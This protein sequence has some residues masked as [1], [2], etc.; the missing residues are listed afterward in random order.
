MPNL[1]IR[2]PVIE[3]PPLPTLLAPPTVPIPTPKT[4]LTGMVLVPAGAFLMGCAPNDTRCDD[5]EK[6][7]HEVFVDAFYIDR[8][9]VTVAAYEQCV[10]A[11]ECT[12]AY[13]ESCNG[14]P[15]DDKDGPQ[16][17]NCVR[18]SD[19]VKY[20]SWVLKRLPTEAEWEK[21][22]R[23]T[24]GRI[25]PWGNSPPSCAYAVLDAGGTGCGRHGT[26]PVGSKPRGASPYGVLDMAGNV[27]EWVADRY[28]PNYYAT[29]PADNPLGPDRGTDLVLRGGGWLYS[30]A[31]LLRASNRDINV[32][33]A[34]ESNIGFRCAYSP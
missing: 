23:G 20:C 19:A 13:V 34:S 27:W 17:M 10:Q 22:A 28:A 7:A 12:R 4:D 14:D 3:M 2:P 25:Y 31:R 5:D 21:A 26:W 11:R 32:G 8:T 29:S 33:S 15:F 18:H 24:D 6:P 30:N 1:E 16:P 9:E